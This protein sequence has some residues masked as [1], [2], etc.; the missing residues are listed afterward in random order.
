MKKNEK[1]DLDHNAL[2]TNFLIL[3]LLLKKNYKLVKTI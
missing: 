1:C 3:F 2:N